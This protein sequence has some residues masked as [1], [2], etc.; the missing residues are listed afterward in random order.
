MSVFQDVTAVPFI[1]II[2]VLGAAA[3][4]GVLAGEL[5][6]A[7]AKAVLTVALVLLAGR[8]LLKPLFHRVAR[9]RSTEVF[10][11]TVLFVVLVAAWTTHSLGLSLAFGAFL[12][13]MA[14]RESE[15]R[16]QVEAS[17]KPFRD[18]LLGLFFVAIGMLLEPAALH[19]NQLPPLTLGER[20]ST[21]WVL[22]R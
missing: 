8:W 9:L 3:G 13:G 15:F 1:V 7:V 6:A 22:S 20:S 5:G 4:A 21:V 10:T 12:A 14:L 19:P 11:L 2:P 16:H 18:V 17:I